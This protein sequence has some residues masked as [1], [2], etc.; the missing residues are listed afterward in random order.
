VD[1]ATFVLATLKDGTTIG[2]RMALGSYAASAKDG[3]DLYIAEIWALPDK[4]GED[5]TPVTPRRGALIK[6]EEIRFIEFS[7]G[8]DG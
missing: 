7:G 6:G 3:R 4:E 5:W 2:G 8:E 1:E